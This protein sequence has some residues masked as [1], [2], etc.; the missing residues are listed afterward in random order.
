MF[1]FRTD[2]SHCQERGNLR[3]ITHNCYSSR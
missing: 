3:W 2:I 1:N